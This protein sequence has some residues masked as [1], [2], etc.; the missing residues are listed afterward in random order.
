[1]AENIW[2]LQNQIKNKEKKMSE[3]IP[4]FDYRNIS[5]DHKEAAQEICGI[6]KQHGHDLTAEL[7]RQRFEL[8]EQKV[9]D[10]VN[11]DVI[12]DMIDA[13]IYCNV[14]GFI[15]EGDIN[16]PMIAI[17]EDVRK[18]ISFHENLKKKKKK[19]AK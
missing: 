2:V 16:Y 12:Q 18:L 6:L 9:F 19:N 1:M 10:H 11:L 8:V 5:D 7:I 17:C 15:K 14:Q 3:Q 4:L 13:G